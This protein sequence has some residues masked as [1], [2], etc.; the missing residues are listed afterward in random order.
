MKQADGMRT[1]IGLQVLFMTA[2][3]GAIFPNFPTWTVIWMADKIL[4]IV[5]VKK[6]VKNGQIE[7]RARDGIIFLRDLQ[8]GEVVKV[9]EYDA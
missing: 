4:D 6:A 8:T 3:T 9:G 7:A 1:E 2:N 5:D